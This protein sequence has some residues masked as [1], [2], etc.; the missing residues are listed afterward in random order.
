MTSPTTHQLRPIGNQQAR[1]PSHGALYPP[2]TEQYAQ[3]PEMPLRGMAGA[4][5]W[6]KAL[7][8]LPV[9]LAST[10][11]ISFSITLIFGV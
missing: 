9:V 7:I 10:A 3:L 4:G 8:E 6:A 5:D 1:R 2:R 11:A